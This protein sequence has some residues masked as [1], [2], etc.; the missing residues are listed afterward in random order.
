VLAHVRDAQG[1]HAEAAAA[2]LALRDVPVAQRGMSCALPWRLQAAVA[3]A[4]TG[5]R[6]AARELLAEQ[7]PITERWGLP[8]AAGALRRATGLVENDPAQLE[9]AAEI[10]AGTPARLE[11]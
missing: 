4:T 11:L 1:R 3:L 5:D 6:Q 9:G 8:R 7:R 2:V 10:I